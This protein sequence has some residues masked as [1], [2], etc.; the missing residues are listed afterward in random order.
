LEY[1]HGQDTPRVHRD[2]KPENILVQTRNPLYVK[3][4]DFSLAKEGDLLSTTC[5]TPTYCP[6][7]IAKYCG[8][9]D[10]VPKEKYTEAVDIWSLGVVVLRFGYSLP[11]PGEGLGVNWCQKIIDGLGSHDSGD[12]IDLLTAAMLVMEPQL[13]YSAEACLDRVS[14]FFPCSREGSLTPIPAPSSQ[15]YEAAPGGPD[16]EEHL[17]QEKLLS[18]SSVSCPRLPSYSTWSRQN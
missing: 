16:I 9:P 10:T 13:R 4:G 6:P 18:L 15:E 8:L 5:G 14:E 17:A 12:L 2:I 3:L 1:L 7:E 11:D